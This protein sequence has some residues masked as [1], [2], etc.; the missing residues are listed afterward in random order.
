MVQQMCVDPLADLAE[1]IRTGPDSAAA[2]AD[3]ASD[4]LWAEATRASAGWVAGGMGAKMA[5]I[6]ANLPE[7]AGFRR[8]LDL[9]GGHGMFALYFVNA[10]PTMK[11]VVFDQPAVVSVAKE[12]IRDY[13][14]QDRVSGRGAGFYRTKPYKENGCRQK[15]F[16]SEPW[17]PW[18]PF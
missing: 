16:L 15:R 9:G 1:R 3:F 14:M 12:F 11:G 5:G 13:G 7:F 4:A 2:G 6:V 10:H 18:P 8:M 17:W